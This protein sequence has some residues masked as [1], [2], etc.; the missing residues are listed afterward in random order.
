MSLS[1]PFM[2]K[3]STIASHLFSKNGHTVNQ[4]KA[5]NGAHVSGNLFSTQKQWQQ[6]NISPL[7][8][9]ELITLQSL[10]PM[11][12]LCNYI[13]L[14]E[15]DDSTDKVA[16]AALIAQEEGRQLYR[17]D[18]GQV[19]SAYVDETEK[20]L[21]TAFHNAQENDWILFFDEA[22]ALFNKRT[23]IQNGHD[24]FASSQV[25]YL[26]KKIENYK[27][28][29]IVATNSTPGDEDDIK[30]KSHAVISFKKN[31]LL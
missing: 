17:I 4:P 28:V 25:D 6:L 16:A 18:V 8:K 19:L 13:A 11:N 3:L 20:K 15:G 29:V 14:F 24:R 1:N 9:A 21:D 26:M 5:T 2:Q 27:G 7:A 23:S 12:R 10:V 30:K 31:D 22:E